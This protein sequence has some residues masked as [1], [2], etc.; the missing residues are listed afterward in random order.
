MPS[1]HHALVRPAL[2]PLTT[3][4][5][6]I[7]AVV[8]TVFLTTSQAGA[9]VSFTPRLSSYDQQLVN[10]IN[11]ARA[12]AHRAPLHLVA[13]TTDVAH[14]WTCTLA[15]QHRLSHRPYLGHAIGRHG[16]PYWR[17]IGENVGAVRSTDPRALF[18]AYMS[19]PEHR[20]NILNARYHYIGVRSIRAGGRTWN[21]LDF[22]DEYMYRYGAARQDC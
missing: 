17:H 22:V 1:L 10:E 8:G 4:A 7:A 5:L 21:T 14:G 19:S 15:R 11:H 3:F 2:I 13:G 12:R 16:S 9:V 20:A 18:H 6:L